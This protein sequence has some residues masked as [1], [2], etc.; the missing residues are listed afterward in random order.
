MLCVHSGRY[1]VCT[2]VHMSGDRSLCVI[3]IVALR[4]WDIMGSKLQ[5][6]FGP[7]GQIIALAKQAHCS[8]IREIH[9][10]TDGKGAQIWR[11][12][13]GRF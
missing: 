2:F 3:M 4:R 13:P 9:N 5:D 12:R 10:T 6:I 1:R 8:I 7:N 11:A